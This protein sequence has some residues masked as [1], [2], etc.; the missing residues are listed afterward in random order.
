MA[1]D[2]R[3]FATYFQ[4]IVLTTTTL[5]AL[6]SQKPKHQEKRVTSKSQTHGLLANTTLS[7]N[8]IG[9]ASFQIFLFI[10][11]ATHIQ[12]QVAW[13]MALLERLK[14]LPLT[15]T[16]VRTEFSEFYCMK[17]CISNNLSSENKMAIMAD[18]SNLVAEN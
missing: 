3:S 9:K 8:G 7:T 5:P 15:A 16:R 1:R 10:S 14:E 6:V 13:L 12:P 11:E 17:W 2:S 18:T 4:C